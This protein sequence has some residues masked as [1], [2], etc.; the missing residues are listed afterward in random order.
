MNGIRSRNNTYDVNM[1][2]TKENNPPVTF[3]TDVSDEMLHRSGQFTSSDSSDDSSDSQ[4][5]GG[6]CENSRSNIPPELKKQRSTTLPE[7]ITAYMIEAPIVNNEVHY[8]TIGN[9]ACAELLQEVMLVSDYDIANPNKSFKCGRWRYAFEDKDVTVMTKQNLLPGH[10]SILG[11]GLI[12]ERL[13]YVWDLIKNPSSRFHYDRLLKKLKVVDHVDEQTKVIQYL[14]EKTDC[15]M[16]QE[17]EILAVQTCRQY[18]NGFIS[19]GKSVEHCQCP[20]TRIPRLKTYGTG[21]YLEPI[22]R[23][24]KQMTKVTYLLQV[25]MHG[26]PSAIVNYVIK[27]QPLAIAYLRGVSTAK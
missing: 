16:K 11:M 3:Y 5:N 25:E 13:D 10:H 23:N 21:F 9:Q 4:V 26:L 8:R 6:Y 22:I 14:F 12:E 17:R 7:H 27:R 15:F 2:A 18:N 1:N 24:E 20:Q 19:A